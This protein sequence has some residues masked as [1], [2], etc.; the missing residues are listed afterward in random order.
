MFLK[1]LAVFLICLTGLLRP[2]SLVAESA[3]GTVH[4]DDLISELVRSNPEV[5]A[6]ET[7]YKVALIRPSI[8]R[9]FPDPRLIFGWMSAGTILPG[10]AIGEDPNSN[11]SI[12]VAQMFP[13]PG[14]RKLR[15]D[16]AEKDA[17]NLKWIQ[18]LEL[19]SRIASLKSTYYELVSI[20]DLLEL[21][22]ENRNLLQQ[23]QNVAEARYS[24][25][26]SVQQDLIRASTEL[27]I[28][29][30]RELSLLQRKLTLSAE[31]NRL[32][33]RETAA[34]LGRPEKLA[35]STLIPFET[36]QSI[37]LQNSPLLKAQQASIDGRKLQIELSKKEVYP[38]LDLMSGYYYMGEL[39]D[40]WEVK[41]E[42]SLP[43]FSRSKQKKETAR[44]GLELAEAQQVHK[45][46]ERTLE[47]RL[48]E[49]YLKAE[50]A[51]K[52]LELYSNRI[53]PQARLALESS[54]ASYEAGTLDFFG[55]LANFTTIL[56]YRM[57]MY[58][59]ESEYSKAIASLE[60]L[61]GTKIPQMKVQP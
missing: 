5:L 29:E 36:L 46:I 39:E 20:Y 23:L 21:S 6:A 44:A 19:N 40:M 60:E 61:I 11:I 26:K 7:R 41:A 37:A 3:S 34:E 4:L 47:V 25:G 32:L 22:N 48:R 31:I 53:I 27:A 56:Q 17:E 55:V 12:Q 57:N 8:E 45:S 18:S 38:D 28:L 10:G 33:N 24:V 43:F 1:Q 35:S 49:A 15:S 42:V 50:T 59:Q 52:L 16:I 58:E 9:T 14:K 30:N 54:L 2:A 51:R 13:Y